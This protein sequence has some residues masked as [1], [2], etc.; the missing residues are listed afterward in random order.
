M[1]EVNT[2]ALKTAASDFSNTL[3]PLV[4]SVK[5]LVDQNTELPAMSWGVIGAMT[6]SG[7]YHPARDYQLRQLK[8]AVKC[9]H[10][11]NAGLYSVALHY[12]EKE[13]EN[14]RAAYQ[15]ANGVTDQ[16][17]AAAKVHELEQRVSKDTEEFNTAKKSDDSYH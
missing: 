4:E 7:N 10:G 14:A 13:L 12:D 5:T 3:L 8:D 9:L 17:K 15:A 6:V 16:S 1:V 11:V 2:A